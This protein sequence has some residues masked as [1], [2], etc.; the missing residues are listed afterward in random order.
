MYVNSVRVERVSACCEY[1]FKKGAKL[2][3]G[4]LQFLREFIDNSLKI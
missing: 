4:T 2:G 3:T 1:K